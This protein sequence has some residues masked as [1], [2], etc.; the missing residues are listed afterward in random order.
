MITSMVCSAQARNRSNFFSSIMDL[1]LMG[2]GVKR[3]VIETLSGLGICHSY[4]KANAVLTRV[5]EA[6]KV[7]LLALFL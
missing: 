7:R 2:S 6:A 1:Y 5:S 4:S 3:R